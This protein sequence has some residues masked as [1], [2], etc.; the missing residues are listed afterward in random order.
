MFFCAVVL[1]FN[2]SSVGHLI[3]SEIKWPNNQQHR[4][5]QAKEQ[6]VKAQVKVQV[7]AQAKA[8]QLKLN[9]I[10]RR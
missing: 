5:Q 9:P 10:S 6:Q 4:A 8:A 1:A 2:Y 7:K 3:F